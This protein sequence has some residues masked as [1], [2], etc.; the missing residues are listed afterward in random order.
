M[1]G[2]FDSAIYD[3]NIFDVGY[4]VKDIQPV[5][6]AIAAQSQA[7]AQGGT[8]SGIG[9]T[10]STSTTSSKF[11]IATQIPGWALPEDE[12][13]AHEWLNQWQSHHTTDHENIYSALNS[14]QKAVG[15]KLFKINIPDL[16]FLPDDEASVNNFLTYNR[17]QH[18]EFYGWLNQLGG[19]LAN[20]G[21]QPIIVYP[22]MNVT[23]PVLD[24]SVAMWDGFLGLERVVHT[25]TLSAISVIYAAYQS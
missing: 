10:V 7:V 18:S 19:A 17:T 1:G 2:I 16:S 20:Y 11:L 15:G 23:G 13:A 21:K 5:Q 9:T 25:M 12:E 22:A 6:Q 8:V 24:D 14:L 3:N 4:K